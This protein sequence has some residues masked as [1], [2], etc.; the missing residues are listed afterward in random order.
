MNLCND[1]KLEWL[2]CED[3]LTKQYFETS[4]DIVL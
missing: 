4:K 2:V 3:C 1:N